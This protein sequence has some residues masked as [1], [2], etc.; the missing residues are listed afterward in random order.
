MSERDGSTGRIPIESFVVSVYVC[1]KEDDR[2]R[3]LLL[4]RKSK[5]MYGLWQQ[6]SGK[7]KK[8]ETGWQ[9]AIREIKEETG[10]VPESLYSADVV[11]SFYEA[12]QN[13]VNIIPVFVAFVG[14]D[15]KVVLSSEHSEYKWLAA[16][17]AIEHVSFPLQKMAID[18]IEKQFVRRNPPEELKINRGFST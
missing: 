7:I 13:C 4:K 16:E 5:Y 8:G 3:Y 9:A 11:E 15:S 12:N 6:V 14:G 18:L 1:K 2:G 10:L 17:E